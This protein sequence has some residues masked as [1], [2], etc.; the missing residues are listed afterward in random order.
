[1]KFSNFVSTLAVVC[2]AFNSDALRVQKVVDV[3]IENTSVTVADN[4]NNAR[5]IIQKKTSDPTYYSQL[6]PKGTTHFV[7]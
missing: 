4:W 3:P 6:Y 2:L 7:C 1:M 5:S